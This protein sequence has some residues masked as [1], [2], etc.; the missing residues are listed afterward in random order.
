MFPSST[1]PQLNAFSVSLQLQNLSK[2][3]VTGNGRCQN[4]ILYT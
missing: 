1:G 2:H 3:I 4:P